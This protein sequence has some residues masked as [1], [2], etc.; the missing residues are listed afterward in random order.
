M[1][2]NGYVADAHCDTL[3]KVYENAKELHFSPCGKM[4]QVFACFSETG[5]KTE[6]DRLIRLYRPQMEKWGFRPAFWSAD[7]KNAM[8][9]GA[10]CGILAIE[11]GGV[12]EGGL[13]VLDDYRAQGVKM[14]TLTWNGKNALASGALSGDAGG[15]SP[16]GRLVVRRMQD[17]GMIVD[18]AHIAETGFWDV[19]QMAQKP[20][21]VSHA[22]AYD[23]CPHKRN[24]TDAQ[25]TALAQTGGL[26]GISFYPVFLGGDTLD[27][28]VAHIEHF[29][30]LG[31][32]K[33]LC[34]GSDFDGIDSLPKGVRGSE[35]IYDLCSLL[36]RLGY[37]ERDVRR[38]AFDNFLQFFEKNDVSW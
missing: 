6:V 18:L 34:I 27:D 7:I 4:V 19:L 29:M 17:C 38:I 21:M 1:P 8:A 33:N 23:I 37:K 36:L 14:I 15:L 11:N 20:V 35:G 30:A 12:L 32:Q 22:N 31:G 16:Y 28:V 25:F 26:L 9:D 24:I 13:S 2:F 5:K 3:E 10:S